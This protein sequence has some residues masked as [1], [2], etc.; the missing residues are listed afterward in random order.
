MNPYE[1]ILE[2]MVEQ[3]AK[4]NQKG[5]ELAQMLSENSCKLRKLNVYKEDL[6]CASHLVGSLQKGDTV[7]LQRI[8]EEKYVIV[9]RVICFA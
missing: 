4:R 6:L 1:E 7:L 5:L 3:G 2:I 8:S 9:E